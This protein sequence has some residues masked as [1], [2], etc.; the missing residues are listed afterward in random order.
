MS[1]G[2]RV[3]GTDRAQL[4]RGMVDLDGQLPDDPTERG[5]FGP[6]SRAWI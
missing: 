5:W 6:L 2:A 1:Q 3:V 4:R